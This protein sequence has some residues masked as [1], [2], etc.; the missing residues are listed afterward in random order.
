MNGR[1]AFNFCTVLHFG[2]DAFNIVKNATAIILFNE[3]PNAI[4]FVTV[5]I[6]VFHSINV[7]LFRIN[8]SKIYCILHLVNIL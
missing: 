6:H 8:Y 2:H 7:Y 4:D 5:R 1:F 3:L